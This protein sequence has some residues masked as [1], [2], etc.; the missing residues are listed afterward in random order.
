M[1]VLLLS[2][3]PPPFGGISSW[4]VSFLDFFRSQPNGVDL[5]HQSTAIKKRKI[6][7]N[8]YL[9]RLYFGIVESTRIIQEFKVTLKRNSPDLI[10]ITS[11]ASFSLI[12]DYCL[13]RIARRKNIP[14]I[15]HLRFGRIPDLYL[16][17]NLEWK[18]LCR[19]VRETS[20]SIL[21]DNN[22]Y[23]TLLKAGVKNITYI[24]NPISV[25]IQ[26]KSLKIAVSK[27]SRRLGRLLFVG[28]VIRQ[29]GIF[30]LVR[31]CARLTEVKELMIVGPCDETTKKKILDIAGTRNN[32]MWINLIGNT[33]REKVLE[34]MSESPVLVLP[35]YTEGFPNVIIEAMAMGCAIIATPVGAIPEIIEPTSHSPAGIC[36]P[37]KDV[38]SLENAIQELL[39][40]DDRIL[41][42]GKSG[43]EKVFT[44]YS[45]QKVSEQYIAAWNRIHN[46]STCSS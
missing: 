44:R 42:M 38:E 24:P 36:I 19:I 2:P 10:H 41:A 22:S 17:N 21:V 16:R 43:I 46:Q 34:Y 33:E 20:L 14:V 4:T 35:S 5:I 11:S 31:A 26:Q 37:P 28:H 45:I 1:K 29:K 25:E 32:G 12:K 39:N 13:I 15:Y 27:R 40:R 8:G 7:S 3:L 6:T 30:E 18:A 23:N 9:I